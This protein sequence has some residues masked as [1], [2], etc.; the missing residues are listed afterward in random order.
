M[1][2]ALLGLI[3]LPP[4][5]P[6]SLSRFA[7][8]V[9]KRALDVLVIVA[10]APVWV[11]L[12]VLLALVVAVDGGAVLRGERRVGQYGRVFLIWTFR[13]LRPGAAGQLAGLL[14]NPARRQQWIVHGAFRDDPR[15]TFAGRWLLRTGLQDL[16][17]VWNVLRGDMSLV[18]PRARLPGEMMR[19]LG[20]MAPLLVTVRPGLTG[21]VTGS[22]GHRGPL[23][24]QLRAE[25][26]YARCHTL[27]GDLGIIG[28]CCRLTLRRTVDQLRSALPNPGAARVAT[29]SASENR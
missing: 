8:A 23:A 3:A 20:A 25:I 22:A 26:A 2:V 27:R 11:P 5:P 9:V 4:A 21:P 10:L 24:A 17:R 13:I 28:R 7:G 12:L 19:D 15:L 6:A 14:A 29:R 18:G 16:P 1:S